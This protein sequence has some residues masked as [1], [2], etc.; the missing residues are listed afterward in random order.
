MTLI[1]RPRTPLWFEVN[2]LNRLATDAPYF[3]HSYTNLKDINILK[4][5]VEFALKAA[6]SVF[7]NCLTFFELFETVFQFPQIST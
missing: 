4:N 5:K 1:T 2:N 3:K 7:G 6:H